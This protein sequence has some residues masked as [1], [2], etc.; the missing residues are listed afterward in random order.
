ME[1]KLE[2]KVIR[3]E[4]ENAYLKSLL[5]QHG[6][7]YQDENCSLFKKA[8]ENNV[9]YYISLFYVRSDV[10]AKR[11]VNKSTGKAGYYPQCVNFWK[12][13]CFRKSGEKISCSKCPKRKYRPL[14]QEVILKHLND[15]S[16]D[17]VIGGYPL[18]E[19][20]SCR[21]I[22]FDFD[23]HESDNLEWQEEV[24]TIRR[25]CDLNNIPCLVERS[26]SGNGGHVWIFFEEVI[27][28]KRAREFGE[29]LLN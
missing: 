22:V 27:E 13:G 2:D 28:A 1:E 4:K 23:N 29:G 17:F 7:K 19:N 3:L 16:G 12:D 11:V 8:N 21:L 20:N 25:I 9:R 5:K 10:Y 18:L 6:I 15:E 26:R 24:N 14:N